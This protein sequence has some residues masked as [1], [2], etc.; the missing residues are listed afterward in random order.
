[1]LSVFYYVAAAWQKNTLP[2]C[3]KCFYP[4]VPFPQGINSRKANLLCVSKKRRLHTNEVAQVHASKGNLY[5]KEK[6]IFQILP[7]ASLVL[8][9]ITRAFWGELKVFLQSNTGAKGFSPIHRQLCND[10]PVIHGQIKAS[11]NS[12]CLFLT[13]KFTTALAMPC[14]QLNMFYSIRP[15]A[16]RLLS[17]HWKVSLASVGGRW[18]SPCTISAQQQRQSVND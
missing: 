14:W 7:A 8:P 5:S 3:G 4:V 12:S 15:R 1:M 13:S 9:W 17:T 10:Y 11:V 16:P 6:C 18:S 2:V